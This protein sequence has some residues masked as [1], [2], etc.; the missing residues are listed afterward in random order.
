MTEP[1][2]KKNRDGRYGADSHDKVAGPSGLPP[3]DIDDD[4][5][6]KQLLVNTNA[7]NA[8]DFSAAD[9]PFDPSFHTYPDLFSERDALNDDIL[10]SPNRRND[11]VVDPV[12]LGLPGEHGFDENMAFADDDTWQQ[13]SSTTTADDEQPWWN[14]ASNAGIIEPKSAAPLV[15]ESDE[16][17][18][19]GA[20]RLRP[21][22]SASAR[23]RLQEDPIAVHAK[24][25][26]DDSAAAREESEHEHPFA[27]D[28]YPDIT[29]FPYLWN[30]MIAMQKTTRQHIDRLETKIRKTRH[31]SF[32]AL[33]LSL[34]TLCVALTAAYLGLKTR[35]DQDAANGALAVYK[36]Q[37][38]DLEE[39]VNKQKHLLEASV[40]QPNVL[41]E[42]ETQAE[43][44]APEG[45]APLTDADLVPLDEQSAPAA[46]RPKAAGANK[47][48]VSSPDRKSK[49]RP[50][51]PARRQAAHR[52]RAPNKTA[53]KPAAKD[54]DGKWAVNLGS[55]RQQEDAD[56]KAEEFRQKRVKIKVSKV[57]VNGQT[58][59]RVSVPGFKSPHEARTQSEKLKQHLNLDSTWIA[60]Y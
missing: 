60:S 16:A 57:E 8:E 44:S 25:A 42:N 49:T 40:A 34:I 10:S 39:A 5:A 41:T 54:G 56:R 43:P 48:P 19:A 11:D 28:S 52:E 1:T 18:E 38:R 58:W 47:K 30:R 46:P 6:I 20:D 35:A 33:G 3:V 14:K 12:D 32:A 51:S 55:F 45:N 15:S 17:E 27:H 2:Y 23:Q 24:A 13:A 50:A 26:A 4:D 21:P 37:M 36:I 59:F 29:E 7:D 22:T 31:L 53:A 9:E